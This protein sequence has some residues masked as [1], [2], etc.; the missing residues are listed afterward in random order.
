[1]AV[2]FAN[3][4]KVNTSTT[5][6]G[7][8][9][10]GSAV[11]GFQSFADGGIVDGNE[12]RYTI[13]DGNAW[14][15]GTGTYTSAGT[16]LSRTLIESS[17]GSLLNL[18]GTN[19][20]VFIT[21]A[22]VDID[23]LATRSM[24]VYNYTATSG[25]TAFT[26]A[27]DNGN[28]LDFLEDNI[29]VTLNGVMLEKTADYTV[30]GGNTVTLTSGAAL[31]DEL[32]V[33]AFK[34]FGIADA[35]AT[36][37]LNSSIDTHLNTSTA[38]SGEYLSWNGSDYDWASVPAGYADSD[39][40]T[41]LNVSGATSGQYLGWNGTDYAWSTVD[42]STKLDLTGGTLTGGLTGTS[43]TFSGDLTVD[44]NTLYVDS[45]NNRVGI[46]TSSPQQQSGIGLHINN[47]SG[48]S[49][50]KL[51]SGTT[52]ATANDGFDVIVESD[53]GSPVHLLQHEAGPLKFG[54]NNAERMR[55]DSSGRVMIG[56]TAAGS[57]Y[58]S[59][60]DLVVGSGSGDNGITIYAGNAAAATMAFADGTTG[61][62]QYRGY[63]QYLHNVDALNFGTSGLERMRIDASGRVTM[64][65]QPAF[66]V[67]HSTN[68]FLSGTIIFNTAQ[69]N[70]GGHYS[71]ST[72]RFTAPVAGN[73][74]FIFATIVGN[75][76]GFSVILQKN[77]SGVTGVG[78]C[79]TGSNDTGVVAKVISLSAG[80]YVTAYTSGGNIEAQYSSFA[81]YL[82]G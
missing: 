44:T 66:S 72:G 22:A 8:I 35:V 67:T 30:S 60:D 76:G 12:V 57:M 36:G 1:M 25:Q 24:D 26:G 16:T 42:L 81:G 37:D 78:Y 41:H 80:D 46:G 5:G 34:Y 7:T 68:A 27:D 18:S 38:T 70:V 62:E 82:V 39:V 43:A 48:Q 17:T 33:T 79:D 73:Y 49:R 20:E 61:S 54:T 53:T 21:M 50:I 23:N 71:T 19:V 32:N 56:N 74:Y 75:S 3:R 6:T 59:W 58:G 15:V 13:I 9:T 4:V 65:Y 64:P 69:V 55:I 28:T 45:T 63:L 29:I 14:E 10:L 47:S 2:K 31:N 51:T 77:G 11:A 52:G 40:D